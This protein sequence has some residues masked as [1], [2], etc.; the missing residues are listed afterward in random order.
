MEDDK[1]ESKGIIV[2]KCSTDEDESECGLNK[3]KDA[4]NE[5]EYDESPVTYNVTIYFNVFECGRNILNR[6][7]ERAWLPQ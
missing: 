3:Q 1:S 2:N 5:T 6:L 4:N 7:N